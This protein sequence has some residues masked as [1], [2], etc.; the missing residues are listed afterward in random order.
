MASADRLIEIFNE[1]KARPAGAERERYLTEACQDDPALKAQV[2][3]LLQAHASAGDF[4]KYTQ[5]ISP[6]ELLTE[7]PGDKIGRYKLL[8]QI[9]EGGCGVV[10]MAEQEEPVRRMVALK[11]IKLGMDTK[12]VIARFE[13]ERQALA[14][15]DHPNIAKV[16][17]A[18]ATDTGRPY[19]VME[20]VRGIKIT[21]YCDQ[22]NLPTRERLKLFVEVCQAVQHAH[23]KGIIHRDIKPSNILVTLRDGVAVPKVIDFGI[24]KATTDQRLTD[25]TLFTA[26]H[27]FIGTPAYMSPEQAEMSEL[28][29][30][31]RSDIY[32][33]GVLLYELLTGQTPFDQK[34]LLAAG[35]DAMRRIIRE[36]E[37]ARPSTRLSTMLEDELTTVASHRQTDAPKLMHL[38][39]GD[40]DW[41]VIKSL[42]KDRARRYETANGLGRDV[43]RYL[44]DE[45]IMARP[46]SNL[47]RFQ[48]SVQRN[49]LAFMAVGAVAAA[50]ALGLVLSMTE[51]IRAKQA[52]REQSRLRQQAEAEQQ[53]ARTETAKAT[54]ISDFL[55]Q[56]L[57][58]ANPDEI[59]GADYSMRNLLDDFSSGLDNRFKDQPEVEAA[60]RETIGKAYYRLSAP[61]KAQPHLERALLLR[62]RIPGGDEQVAETLLACSWASFGLQQCAKGESQAREALDIYRKHGTIGQPVIAAFLA[63]QR[64]LLGE[65]RGVDAEAVTEEA[66]TVA[67]KS[68][69]VEFPELATMIHGLAEVRIHQSRFAEAEILAQE[70]VTME[71]RLRGQGHLETGWALLTLGSALRGEQKLDA[72]ESADRQALNIFRRQFP[73]GEKS[74]D[75]TTWELRA[76]LEAKGDF[77]R[78]VAFD[79]DMLAD[80]RLA[81]GENSPSVAATLCSLGG[82]LY[83]QHKLPEAEQACQGAL[84]I[85]M[86]LGVGSS[87]DY[88]TV[89]ASLLDVLKAENKLVEIE[90]LY[91]EVLTAQRSALGDDSPTVAATLFRLANFLKSQNRPGD[92]AQKYEETLHIIL[93]PHWEEHLFNLSSLVVP[94][95]VE[96][97]DKPQAIGIC[98]KMLDA[99]ITNANWF[100]NASWSLATTENPLNRD[101]ALAVELA[102]KSIKLSADGG[103]WN[104]LGVA[105]YRAGDFKQALADL[106]KSMQLPSGETSFNYFFVAMANRQLGNAD[107]ARHYYTQAIQWMKE[108]DPQ[109]T[110]LIRFRAEAE[111]LLDPEDKFGDENQPPTPPTAK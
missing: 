53:K 66:S 111:Q 85:Y 36:K 65:D 96:A 82:A 72:A 48:K 6:V 70:A 80:Q 75:I 92:A 99:S 84:A 21:E 14:L 89:V 50:L 13:A 16:L 28:G 12:Q 73:K 100:N 78:L 105:R 95:L 97:G 25:K 90:E 71:C 55:Q 77:A 42:E 86:K 46:P 4:L 91:R 59:K 62:R 8:Q 10:Y 5:F 64:N 69:G 29:I 74:V 2:I 32:S 102:E 7:K 9:G 56:S 103:D 68:T 33:L 30:D 37:P 43:E 106:E 47:Y 31:T 81:L 44:A 19:F 15:M 41:I 39:R 40:L 79:Q 26:F 88:A 18:G 87:D 101:P 93:K 52:E 58:S 108:H 110:E 49:K 1:A 61:D 45:P 24:A 23:Q 67:R 54:A 22:N 51:A 83:Q 27:Q 11:V 104:T 107:A 17:D 20:L 76:V 57:Q 94:V 98:R 60:M 63:L 3:A 38:L 34:E 35:L 109:S